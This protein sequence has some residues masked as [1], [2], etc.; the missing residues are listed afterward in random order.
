MFGHRSFLVIGGGG[1]VNIMS[2]IKGGYELANCEFSFQQGMDEKGQVQTEVIG[3][4]I[5]VALPMLPSDEILLWG[6]KSKEYRD[7][8]IVAVD[9][10]NKP[11]H[12]IIF[13]N[14]ACIGLQI[15]Y[16][17]K[18]NAYAS[19]LITIQAETIV[20][21]TGVKFKNRWVDYE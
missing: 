15:G 13:N 20:V 18:G 14:A 12:K 1:P 3:G 6:M 2:L 4:T 17:R 10:E 8:M 9:E 21:G 11:M 19:T 7:G 16:K 5:H